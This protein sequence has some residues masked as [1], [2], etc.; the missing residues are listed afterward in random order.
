MGE[1][2]SC[3]QI[4]GSKWRGPS[5]NPRCFRQKAHGDG[6]LSPTGVLEHFS[7]AVL[8]SD[9]E[10]AKVCPEKQAGVGGALPVKLIESEQ[11]KPPCCQFLKGKAPYRFL[12]AL[13]GIRCKIPAF[14]L[15]L[16]LFSVVTG[17][18]GKR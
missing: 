9:L 7:L 11:C 1:N 4:P 6:F 18:A 13:L 14:K 17:E 15:D 16:P 8:L 2:I 3:Y 12:N 5:E 10:E